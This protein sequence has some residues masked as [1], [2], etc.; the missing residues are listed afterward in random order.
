MKDW[1]AEDKLKEQYWS[2]VLTGDTATIPDEV[3]RKAGA[4]GSGEE[5]D[6]EGVA[7]AVNRSWAADHLDVPREKVRAQWGEIRSQLARRFETG[8]DERE[9][10]AALSHEQQEMAPVRSAVRDAD[11][12]AYESGF[13][14]G[15]LPDLP[16]AE[17]LSPFHR[18]LVSDAARAAHLE[19]A[20]ERKRLMPVADVVWNGMKTIMPQEVPLD[21]EEKHPGMLESALTSLSSAV[22]NEKATG[23][24]P[25]RM[26]KYAPDLLAAVDR[27][28]EMNDDERG[29][30]Y[31]LLQKRARTE[32]KED[33]LKAAMRNFRR[34]AQDVAWGLMQAGGNALAAGSQFLGGDSGTFL[35]WDARKSSQTID[36]RMRML[37]EMRRSFQNDILPLRLDDRANAAERT[38]VDASRSVAPALL[39]LCGGLGLGAMIGS[40]MGSS[41][42]EMRQQGPEGSMASQGAAALAGGAFDAAANI[43]LTK[44]GAG[45]LKNSLSAFAG[46]QALSSPVSAYLG[47]AGSTA[48]GIGKEALSL[49]V[50]DKAS[51]LAHMGLQEMAAA[52]DGYDSGIDW[53]GWAKSRLDWETQ[54]REAA[55]VLPFLLIGSGRVA[56]R[57]FKSVPSVLGNGSRL[58]SWGVPEEAIRQ[59]LAE[60]DKVRQGEMLRQAIVRSPKWG[61]L[62]FVHQASVVL[63]LLSPVPGY[64]FKTDGA[65]RDFLNL[66][67]D[68]QPPK[69]A[70]KALSRTEASK[71]YEQ[72]G[73]MGDPAACKKA[74]ELWDD[75]WSRSGLTEMM[76]APGGKRNLDAC[77]VS[78]MW[79]ESRNLAELAANEGRDAL[80]SRVALEGV[81]QPNLAED[82]RVLLYDRMREVRQRPF[83][84]LMSRETVDGLQLSKKPA[85]F[86]KQE[87]RAV[88]ERMRAIVY[89]GVIRLWRGEEK[90]RVL[91]DV[92]RSVW[93]IW[94]HP[95]SG[96][97]WQ[98]SLRLDREIGALEGGRDVSKVPV[99]E[100]L[101]ELSEGVRAK[102][103]GA[104][105]AL[106]PEMRQ[107]CRLVWGAQA[108]V[109]MLMAMMPLQRDFDVAM[110]RGF[111]PEE[112]CAYLLQRELDI[113]P[114]TLAKRVEYLR[115]AEVRSL[116]PLQEKRNALIRVEAAYRR[117]AQMRGIEPSRVTGEDGREYWQTLYPNGMPTRWHASREDMLADWGAHVAGMFA[118]AGQSRKELLQKWQNG[119]EIVDETFEAYKGLREKEKMSVFEELGIKASHDLMKKW[120]GGVMHR[121]PGESVGKPMMY[122]KM[123]EDV[124]EVLR[125]L[126]RV[127]VKNG[128][129]MGREHDPL[130]LDNPVALI[131]GK[132]DTV[133]HRLL[134]TR[135]LST[136]EAVQL[137]QGAGMK[138]DAERL[139]RP[140]NRR[141]L[142]LELTELSKRYFMDHLNDPTVPPALLSWMRYASTDLPVTMEELTQGRIEL[143]KRLPSVPTG[144]AS[145][146]DVAKWAI[147]GAVSE[148]QR[149]AETAGAT[150]KAEREGTVAPHLLGMLR[151]AAGMH[152]GVR[153]ER[154]WM[155]EKYPGR[156][157]VVSV[158]E[159]LVHLLPAN[160]F[161]EQIAPMNAERLR[162]TLA[163]V[164]SF[165][166]LLKSND[167]AARGPWSQRSLV[168][169][170]QLADV[171]RVHPDLH[172]W[173]IDRR[174]P[175]RFRRI[176]GAE[177]GP[178]ANREYKA[179]SPRHYRSEPPP[180]FKDYEVADNC[181]LPDAWRNDPRIE[182][183][184]RTLDALR[185]YSSRIPASSAQG[186][187]WG[188]KLLDRTGEHRPRGV[189][190][191]WSITAPLVASRRLLDGLN[192]TFEAFG[193][194]LQKMGRGRP[195]RNA[196]D[197]M[198]VYRDP[199][200]PGH[201]VR[202]MPGFPDAANLL[203]RGPYVVHSYRGVYLDVNGNPLS[204]GKM[205]RSYIP[206]EKFR[207]RPLDVASLGD[208]EETGRR[209]LLMHLGWS[210]RPTKVPGKLEASNG[211]V[212]NP[213]ELIIR[214]EDELG[215]GARWE[216]ARLETLAPRDIYLLRAA[217]LVLKQPDMLFLHH[218]DNANGL[219]YFITAL[220]RSYYHLRRE[221]GSPIP[222]P[223]PGSLKK[224]KTDG[225]DN[226]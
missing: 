12:L 80:P 128:G 124:R 207:M 172:E 130:T 196:L 49:L 106:S 14:G 69:R 189:G 76:T 216:H 3:R 217:R 33:M 114:A 141:E 144:M 66:P 87:A 72:Y 13:D 38:V 57:H 116:K 5:T 187:V 156:S 161:M 51:Q 61:G 117:F 148:V 163:Y 42:A 108:D 158:M 222:E 138:I 197:L 213:L 101:L 168:R 53:S 184:I 221:L 1:A 137:L 120:Y 109:R 100:R 56:L 47:A 41:M 176:V 181:M 70:S 68:Y 89:E 225:K 8:E 149:L 43:C 92:G 151:D 153:A 224:K 40:G 82:A 96:P 199:N 192:A 64:V 212:P 169:L 146:R 23:V 167:E 209:N 150:L 198:V 81:F 22:F 44:V 59:I 205:R 162:D 84:L 97:E 159:R 7:L 164:T 177:Y 145:R 170:E 63:N 25:V 85:E 190:K 194:K 175:G 105:N 29:K 52:E 186:V 152:R 36:R 65:V 32:K 193:V 115:P 93:K 34:G 95:A 147:R 140:E 4:I 78:L 157:D 220:S 200:L 98:A 62:D 26:A 154:A 46:R 182:S 6:E 86:W 17:A 77:A 2:S 185:R 24:E 67:A 104:V 155:S 139:G 206:L 135:V 71:A 211:I 58:K 50:Y 215:Q 183:A 16:E 134:N 218:E 121:L 73:L 123:R 178:N 21:E 179:E 90:N 208:I 20:A 102:G 119:T 15:G 223:P 195:M 111:S 48:K 91:R 31:R 55:A 88:D 79:R 174:V 180:R 131:Q 171:L 74:F 188:S 37:E 11:R 83:R 45:M 94:A 136:A 133:W 110:S 129:L 125:P 9:L 165:R 60:R 160:R 219:K 18:R 191:D 118:P 35:G 99:E 107:A 54:R 75:W 10:F 28:S 204:P 127:T 112:S 30:V 122:H 201:V 210:A 132:S 203:A 166:G 39:S 214:L 103:A 173:S 27:L 142:I 113:R 202:L 126:A 19:G 226:E 143:E